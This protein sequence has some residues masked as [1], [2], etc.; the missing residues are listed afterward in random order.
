ME[1]ANLESSTDR[2]GL[3]FCGSQL[4]ISTLP[5]L[6]AITHP[7]NPHRWRSGVTFRGDGGA[8]RVG[9]VVGVAGLWGHALGG[10]DSLR[11]PANR[12]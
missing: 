6:W 9:A 2:W 1:L 11:D 10:V 7:Q 3:S 4:L 5:Y 12:V 8:D